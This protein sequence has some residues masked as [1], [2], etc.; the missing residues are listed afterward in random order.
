[1]GGVVF[2][3]YGDRIGRKAMLVL[4]L[5]I[6]GIATFLI[7]VLPTYETIGVLAPILLVVLRFLQGI[8]V[9][10]EWGG[11]VLMAVEHAPRDGEASTEAGRRWGLPPGCCSPTGLFTSCRRST[12]EQFLAWG[13]RVPFLLS[14]VL[15]GVGLFIRLRIMETPAFTQVKE[16]GTEA[17]MPILD[18]LRTYPQEHLAR[19]GDARR[20]E[21][22]LLH[23][24]RLRAHLR[25]KG[26]GIGPEHAAWS[27]VMIAAAIEFAHH[28]RSSARSPT[29]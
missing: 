16:S 4:T 6:M 14:I 27:A 19:D 20:R 7:G 28:P 8:G 10:G 13:W 24:H 29:A 15:V 23:L 21:R 18:V 25:T 2:G 26:A 17:P 22:C 3:H 5:L 12:E 11:A 1:M 9:G